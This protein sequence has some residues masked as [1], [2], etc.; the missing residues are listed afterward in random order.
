MDST[1]S[2]QLVDVA[3]G[4]MMVCGLLMLAHVRV[5]SLLRF[6]AMQSFFLSAIAALTAWG[7]GRTHLA[8]AAALVFV[9]KVVFIP[10]FMIALMK[11]GKVPERLVGI[12]KPTASLFGGLIMAILA[13]YLTVSLM[14]TMETGF[15]VAAVSVALMLM[16]LFMLMTKKGLYGQIGGFLLMENG[17]FSF[18]LALTGGMSLLIELGIF[19]DVTVGAVLMAL[20]TYRVHSM[21]STADTT[22]LETLID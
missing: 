1:V 8:Y 2:S 14:P 7:E 20:L 13:F 11:K 12:L 4:L 9:V 3:A 19:F 17:I 22:P 16:G 21:A 18:G 15:F 5:R 6:F 10:F